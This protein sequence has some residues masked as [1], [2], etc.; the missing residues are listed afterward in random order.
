MKSKDKRTLPPNGWGLDFMPAGN[1]F[2]P[3]RLLREHIVRYIF[4]SSHV[5]GKVILDIACGSGYGTSYLS[6][7]GAR[8]VIGGDASEKA[9]AQAIKYFKRENLEFVLLD[10]TRMPIGDS[11]FEV[12]VSF[13]TIEHIPDYERFL[14]ECHRVLR[15]DGIFICSTPNVIIPGTEKSVNPYHVNEFNVQQ[16]DEVLHRYFSRVE[17]FGEGFHNERRTSL[18]QKMANLV[19]DRLLWVP[20]IDKVNR[21]IT[22]FLFKEFRLLTISEVDDFDALWNEE[23]KPVRLDSSSRPGN[24]IAIA[25]K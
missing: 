7:K 2:M 5:R 12:I 4:A 1:L 21:F 17:L 8:S 13:E 3:Y 10:A 22:R 20:Y 6:G 11:T 16:V 9:I 14:S 18:R 19:K 23:D 24:I 15:H 25:H